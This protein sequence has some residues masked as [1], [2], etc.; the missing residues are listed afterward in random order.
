[1]ADYQDVYRERLERRGDDVWAEGPDGWRPAAAHDETIE[2]RGAAAE[3]VEVVVTGSGPVFTGGPGEESYSLR[4]AS[5]ALGD[6]GFSCLLPLLRARTAAQVCSALTGWVEPVNNL[7]VA[8][9]HGD[10]R[11]AVVGRVPQRADANRWRPVPG[12]RPEHQWTGWLE[13]LPTGTVPAD[14]HLVTA[15]H[16]MHEGFDRLGVDFAP[17]G[18]ARRIEALLEGRDNLTTD[19]F[20]AI[21]SDVLA[22]QPATLAAAVA[23]LSGLTAA[24]LTL[25]RELTDWDQQFTADSAA[26][27]AYAAVRDRLVLRLSATGPFPG[28]AGASSHGPLLDAWF[29]VPHQLQ[30]SL[31]NLLS[32]EGRALVPGLEAHLRAA[33]EEVAAEPPGPWGPRHRYD[34]V[35]PLG[36]RLGERP[37][38]AGDDDCV[39]CTGALPGSEVAY[40]GSVARYSWDL[41]GFHRSGWVVPLGASGDPA[42]PHHH[43]QT[44]PWVEAR[45]LPLPSL[46]SLL[47]SQRVAAPPLTP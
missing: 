23:G 39:R 31:R 8:D 14:G 2:V 7:V 26:A 5:Y 11:Q 43:D 9:V 32:Q 10:A 4:T 20:A 25:Q 45:L 12:W 47:W 28:L 37:A 44:T 30:L 3:H 19:D 35:H 13:G 36:L 1:M 34:P 29:D 21:H 15:N 46:T 17:P 24:G 41:G 33:V 22:G 6:L 38:L 42:S 27:A 40:R 16:R 18:R